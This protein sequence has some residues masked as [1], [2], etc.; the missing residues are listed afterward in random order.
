MAKE[1]TT[2]EQ[3]DIIGNAFKSVIA[4]KFGSLE[5]PPPLF[6][7]TGIKHLDALLGG[8]IVSSGLVMVSSTPE[9]GKST[10][11]YQLA[12]Q[13]I[14]TKENSI[15]VYLDCEGAGSVTE[16]NSSMVSRIDAFGLGDSSR[17]SYHPIVLNVV[18]LFEVVQE[19]VDTKKA[20]EAKT[21]KEFLLFIIW[22][23]IPASPCSKSE[24]AIDHNKI[25][26]LFI[27]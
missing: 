14:E 2:A 1:K 12:K 13:M 15:V 3:A 23:S 22:D 27:N 11:A 17:F 5:A 25:I 20:V 7:S 18:Q 21:G 16:S 6:F 9:T 19:L 26:G 8:G 24:E 4:K 10:F